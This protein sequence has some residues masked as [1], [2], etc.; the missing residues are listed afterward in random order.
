M[1]ILWGIL[2]AMAVY[3]IDTL[4]RSAE[5]QSV[6][7]QNLSFEAGDFKVGQTGIILTQ[8]Q[9]YDVI[10][11]NV[12]IDRIQDKQAIAS[13]SPLE[14]IVQKYLPTPQI[15]PS[16][17]DKVVFGSFYDKAIIIAPDQESYNKIL[18]SNPQISFAHIDLFEAFLAKDGINDPKPKEL[19]QFCRAYSVGLVYLLASN[20]VNILDCQSFQLLDVMAFDISLIQETKSPFF[21]R[22]PDIDTGSLMSKLRS[23]KSRHY[24]K[25]YDELIRAPLASF[26]QRGLGDK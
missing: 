11:G 25:Y 7:S 16:R 4:P 21:S 20:G 6:S 13:Y 19:G 15:K 12:V 10:I 3:A 2:C 9:G 1:R 24:F 18:I 14:T 22:I 26:I 23:K 5:I 17:G 8:T